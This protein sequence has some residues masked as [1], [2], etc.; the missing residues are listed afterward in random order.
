[1]F[2]MAGLIPQGMKIELGVMTKM[3]EVP[4]ISAI[5]M[6]EEENERKRP[7]SGIPKREKVAMVGS[8]RLQKGMFFF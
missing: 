1:M 5:K 3:E 7:I 2:L 8:N 6:R 4:L